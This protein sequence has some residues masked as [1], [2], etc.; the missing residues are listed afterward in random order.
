METPEWERLRETGAGDLVASGVGAVAFIEEVL[1]A[2]PEEV[3]E[4]ARQHAQMSHRAWEGQAQA[5]A[6]A[7]LG[8]MLR[9]RAE[10][11]AEADPEA[12]AATQVRADETS[13]RALEALAQ[14]EAA[15]AQADPGD[16]VRVL[17]PGPRA[18]L[19]PATREGLGLLL[20]GSSHPD[21]AVQLHHPW[22]AERDEG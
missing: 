22:A 6:L 19:Q 18:A 21:S 7:S 20:R 2:L 10:T 15:Q 4:Q 11:Q 1:K 8:E 9:E 16:H 13:Q 12:A 3:K 14:A 5:Q 17:L